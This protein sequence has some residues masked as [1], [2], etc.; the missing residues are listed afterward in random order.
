MITMT[1]AEAETKLNKTLTNNEYM[2]Y[3]YKL[4]F[5]SKK[6]THKNAQTKT[7][8]TTKAPLKFNDAKAEFLQVGDS[9]EPIRRELFKER[10]PDRKFKTDYEVVT[11]GDNRTEFTANLTCIKKYGRMPIMRKELTPII[12]PNEFIKPSLLLSK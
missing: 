8:K 11:N 2:Q 6:Q 1:K 9:L 4:N 3:I 12:I 10:F 5:G 7:T